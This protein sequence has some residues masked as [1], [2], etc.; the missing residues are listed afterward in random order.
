VDYDLTVKL[1]SGLFRSG[2]GW[3]RPDSTINARTFQGFAEYCLEIQGYFRVIQDQ[4]FFKDIPGA[5]EAFHSS[6]IMHICDPSR[7][8]GYYVAEQTFEKL[9]KIL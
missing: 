4:L 7:R 6:V 9:Y 2:R 5:Y 8:T 1:T 3:R